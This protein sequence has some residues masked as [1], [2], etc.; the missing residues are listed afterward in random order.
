MGTG[1]TGAAMP[2]APM[3]G[4][5]PASGVSGGGPGPAMGGGGVGSAERAWHAPDPVDWADP[6]DDAAPS[7]LGD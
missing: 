5:A 6:D 2:M 4:V 3:G 1:G 7:V